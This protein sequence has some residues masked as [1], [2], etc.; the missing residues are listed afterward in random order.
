VIVRPGSFQPLGSLLHG[1]LAMSPHFPV[2]HP[3]RNSRR[4]TTD[5][6]RNP[7]HQTPPFP[8]RL[9][10]DESKQDAAARTTKSRPCLVTRIQIRVAGFSL[11][12][13]DGR[14][15]EQL[16]IELEPAKILPLDA[17][18]THSGKRR[19][20]LVAQALD[21]FL[22]VEQENLDAVREGLD[23][24]SAGRVVDHEEVLPMIQA[25]RRSV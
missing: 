20:E 23:D 25:L 11:W 5:I 9:D 15:T 6:H 1:H 17:L 2:N 10:A 3:R 13:E 18:S 16:Q 14:M 7:K 8:A 22:A 12:E 4:H 21:D 19:E 24:L